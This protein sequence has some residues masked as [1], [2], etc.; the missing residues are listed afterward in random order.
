MKNGI[1]SAAVFAAGSIVFAG[2]AHAAVATSWTFETAPPADVSAASIGPLAA[3]MGIGSASGVHASAATTWTTPAG[4]GSANSLSANNYAVG[5]YFQF[6]TSTTGLSDIGVT[7][8]QTGSN[9][10]PRDWQFAYSTDG[11]N[12][13]N[14]GPVYSLI[15]GA[16]SSGTP[17]TTTSF[18]Y[19]LSSIGAVENASSVFFRLS[20]ASTTAITGGTVAATGTGRV[21]NFTVSDG[22]PEPAGL[23]V[24][25]L[26]GIVELRRRRRRQS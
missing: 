24:I 20:V 8:D 6:Q 16:W 9:T 17:V 25:G 10:G 26:A 5:D 3:D 4:N 12:F 7:F 18:S 2:S 14:L 22:V 1:L 23:G 13:T 11:T 19:D 15:N 21:D